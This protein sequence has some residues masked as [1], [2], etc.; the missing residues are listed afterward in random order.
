MSPKDLLADEPQTQKQ[1]DCLSMWKVRSVEFRFVT[2]DFVRTGLC[3][4]VEEDAS[5]PKVEQPAGDDNHKQDGLDIRD[6]SL[7][8]KDRQARR[9][10]S[11]TKSKAAG[12]CARDKVQTPKIHLIRR[13]NK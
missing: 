11:V 8:T 10:K 3:E 4:E 6:D 5:E 9:P 12:R 1:R 13:L 2:E 7:P